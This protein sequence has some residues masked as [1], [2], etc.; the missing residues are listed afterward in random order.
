MAVQGPFAVEFEKVF[1]A[2][3]AVVGEVV[4][5]NDF[6]QSTAQRK[7][8]Q[9]DKE[10]GAPLW[11]VDILDFDPEAREKTVRVKIA[12]AVSPELPPVS[13]A[14]PLRPVVLEG[15][16]VTPY[17]KEQGSFSRVAYSLRATG[18]SAPGRAGR[19]GSSGEAAA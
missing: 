1:P 2:G 13:D 12:S 9:R 14:L 3:A 7:V 8:Q 16:T 11:A 6:D 10:S 15:L 4:P 18:M 19:R 5:V 17:L